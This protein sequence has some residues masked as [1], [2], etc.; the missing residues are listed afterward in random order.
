MNRIVCVLGMAFF[1]AVSIMS[2]NEMKREQQARH[3]FN[4]WLL[5][6]ATL[7]SALL[8]CYFGRG[9]IF[10]RAFWGDLDIA[11]FIVLAILTLGGLAGVTLSW[12]V[13]K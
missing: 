1:L 10:R 11:Y 6:A 2:L 3:L 8:S 5:F 12:F 9:L 4:E 13:N 7:G